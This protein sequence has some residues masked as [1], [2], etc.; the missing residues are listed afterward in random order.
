M[1]TKRKKI[2][3]IIITIIAIIGILGLFIKFNKTTKESYQ[4]NLKLAKAGIGIERGTI[5]PIY[6]PKWERV[7]T[8]V[9]T[10]NKTLSVVVKGLANESQKINANTNINYSSDVTSTLSADDITVYINGVEIT[11]KTHPKVQV[12]EG[13]VTTNTTTGK[14]E[15]THTIL[16]SDFDSG[17]L[18]KTY[19]EWSGNVTL[20]IAGR[21]KD[22]S[23]YT[24]NVLKDN[25]YGNRSMMEIDTTGTWVDINMKDETTDHY[26]AGVMFTDFID[27][28]LTYNYSTSDIN[29]DNK[30]LTMNFSVTDKYFSST[31]LRDDTTGSNLTVQ[32]KDD[33]TAPVNQNI[34]KELTYLGDINDTVNGQTVKV[35][36]RYKLVIKGLQQQTLDG[37]Y[38]NYSGPITIAFPKG[39]VK[40]KSNNPSPAK[41]ITIGVN[42]PDQTGTDKIV[43]VVDP[44]WKTQNINI[45][46]TNNKVTVDLLGTDKYYQ[47]NSLTTDKIKVIVD[48]EEATSI[49]KTLSATP[50]ALKETRNGQ[51]VQYGIQYT[52]TLEN[53]EQ[54]TKQTSPVSKQF[55]EWSG[56][57][58]IEIAKDT[59]TDQSGNTSNAQTFTLGH[60][61]FIKPKIER[62]SSTKDVTA[63]TETIVFNVFDKYLKATNFVTEDE[64]LVY[65]DNEL[66]SEITKSI[67]K[68]TEITGLVNNTNKV[69]GHQYTL[70]LGNF[71]QTRTAINFDREYSDWSGNVKIRIKEGAVEDTN[72]PTSNKNAQTDIAGEF[73]DFIKPNVTYQYSTSNIKYDNKTFTMVFD[74]TDK[75]FA[76]S[77]LTID[78]LTIKIDNKDI[79]WTK[80]SKSL[81]VTDRTNVVNGTSKVIGKRYTLELSNLEQLLVKDGDKYLDYSGV[82]TV[83]VPKNKFSD[84]SGNWNNE[85]TITSGI[86]IPGGSGNGQVVDVVD[87]LVEKISSSAN[88]INKTATVKFKV[89]DKYFAKSTITKDNIKVIINGQDTAG[90]TRTL[91]ST[92]LKE[93]RTVNGTTTTVQYGV[94]YTVTISGFASDV[95]Q[96]KVK[97]PQGY[98]T[99]TYNNGNKETDLIVYNA[100]KL[101]DSES[102]ATSGFLGSASNTN[103]TIKGI[104]RQNIDNVTFEK[105]IPN[106][107]YD[108]VAKKITDKTKAWDVSAQGDE[109]IVAWFVDNETKNGTYKIHI[110]SN[111]AQTIKEDVSNSEVFGNMNSSNLFKCIGQSENCTSAETITNLNLLNTSSV[112]NMRWMFQETGANAMTTL[113]LGDFDTSNVTHMGA[114]FAGT[115]YNKMT[116]LNLGNKFNTSKV[117]AMDYMFNNTGYM[118]MTDL[119]LGGEFNTSKVKLMQY[120]FYKTGHE[121]MVSLDLG[122][123]FNT[124]LVENMSHMFEETGYTL[125]ETLNLGGQFNTSNVTEMVAMFKNCGRKMSGLNLGKEFNTVKVT[126]MSY[127]F[128]CVGFEKL[129]SL[130]LGEKFYTSNVNNM[131]YMFAG[132]G[133]VSPLTSI[134]LGKEFDTSNVTDMGY[135]FHCAGGAALTSLDLGDKFD[136]SK[137]TNMGYMFN[138]CGIVALTSLDLGPMF[139]QI[140]SARDNMFNNT[141]KNG[142]ITI[143][144][145]EQIY[146]DKNNFKLNTNATSSAINFTRGTINPKY[147]TEWVKEASELK[148]DTSDLSKSKI[149]ITLR[150]RTNAEAGKDHTSNVSSTLTKDAV[151]VFFDNG[152]EATTITKEVATATTATNAIT[153][154]NDVIQVIT[155]SN[156]EEASRQAGKDYKEWSGNISLKID[157]K[158]LCDIY[159]NQNLKAIDTS[160]TMTD[161]VIKEDENIDANSSGTMFA[162]YIR[163][164]FT[165]KYQTEDINYG[166]KILTVDFSVT[167]KYFSSTKLRKDTKAENITVNLK[168]DKNAPVNS[169]IRKSLSYIEDIN[170]TV[171]GKTVKVGEKYRLEI[172]GLEQQTLDGKYKNYS[173]PMTL[174]FPEG[175][176]TDK[177]GNT[178]AA[179][180]ITIGVNEPDQTGSDKIVDVVDPMWRTDNIKIDHDNNK[181]TVDLIGTDKYYASNSLTTGKIK[182]IVDGEEASSITKTLSSTPEK[183]TETRNGETVQY[184]VKYTLTL[185]DW[186]QAGK[187]TDPAKSF[188]EW[189]GTT[190]IEI[191]K[192]TLTDEFGNTNIWQEFELGHVDFI[193][194]KIE[195]V[196]ST[197]NATNK[198]ETIVFNVFDKYL[199][200]TDQ[201]TADEISV[202]VDGESASQISKTLTKTSDIT[203]LVNNTSRI[204][205][206]QY[207]LVLG[208]FEQKRTS[209][210]YDREYSDWSGNV[211]IKVA[212]GAVKDTNT[213]VPNK[214]I[215]TDI[216]GEFIDF[217]KPNATYQYS[218]SDINYDGKTFTMVFDMTDKHYASGTLSLNDLAIR[219]D[220]EEPNW[221]DT[222]VHGVIKKLTVTDRTNTVNGQTKVIGKR[223]TL[224]LS[225]LEQLEKLEGKETM[226][227]SGVVTVA[228]PANKIVDTTGNKNN[229]LTITSGIETKGESGYGE[230][231]LP[232]YNTVMAIGTNPGGSNA[233][234]GFANMNVY[235]L[236]IS[237]E[238]GVISS[239]DATN[240]TGNGHNNSSTTWKDLTGSNTGTINGATWENDYLKL[241]GV[242]DWVN[243]G[244]IN[245]TNYASLDITVSM[246]SVSGEQD[247]VGNW[248]GGGVGIYLSGGYPVFEVFSKNSNKYVNIRSTS[249]I[250]VN[251]K[252][253]IKAIYDGNNLYLYINGKPVT[254]TV[255]DVVDPIWERVSSSAS[256]ANKTATVTVKGT[257]KY[258]ASSKLTADKIKVLVN[259]N[260][261]SSNVSVNVE[262]ATPVYS[263]DGTTRIGDKYT[264]T[265][266]GSG[267]PVDTDQIKVQIQP[268]TITDESGNTNKVTDLL[269]YNT[270]RKTDTETEATSGFLGS[271]NS[272]NANVKAIQRQNIDNVTFIDKI[273]STIYD[274]SAKKILDEST[275]WDVSAMQDKS[276]LAWYDT[277]ANGSIKVYIG[278]DNEIFANYN[279]SYLFKYIGF[280][281]KCTSTET[282]TNISLLNVGSVTKMNGMFWMTG[283]KSMTKLE[284]G[285]NFDTSNVESMTSMFKEAG[286]E[287]MT[288]FSLGSK[289]NT[290]KVTDMSYM[291]ANTGYELLSSLDLKDKFFTNKVTD[292]NNMF[293]GTGYTSMTNFNLGKEFNTQN[294][295][296]MKAMFSNTGFTAMT[297]LN[298]GEQFYTNKVKNMESMFEQTGYTAMTSLDLGENFDT[299]QVENMCAMFYRTGRNEMTSLNLGENFDTSNVTNMRSMFNETGA[300][301]MTSLDLGDKFY[302]NKVT[303]MYRMFVLTGASAM[304]KLDLGP[305]FTAIP[306]G[307]I[308]VN[309]N[310]VKVYDDIFYNTGKSRAITIYASEQIYLEKNNFKLNTDQTNSAIEFTR[311]TIN[312]KYRTEWVKESAKITVKEQENLNESKIEITLR[313][314]TNAE[315][316][317]NYI[318]DV[319]SSLK[320]ENIHI[321]FDGEEAT[322]ISKELSEVTT[323]T[324]EITKAQ[325]VKHVLTITNFEEALRQQGKNYKEWSGNISLKIDKKTLKDTTYGNQNLQAIDTSGTM[326]DIEI[327]ENSN[328]TQNTDGKMFTDYIKPEFTYEYAN[329]QINY[330]KKNITVVFDVTDKYFKESTVS[331]NNM[332]IKVDG[333]EPDWTKVERQFV[334][335]TIPSEQKIG[336]IIYKTNGDIYTIVNGQEQKIGE[337]YELV[338]NGLE[339]KNGEGYSGTVTLAFPEGVITD[340]SGNKNNSKTLTIGVDDP[341]NHPDHKDPTIVDVVNPLWSYGTSSI[342]RV[343]NGAEADTVDVTIIGSDKYYK[344]NTLT[345]DKIKVYVDDKLESSISKNITQITDANTLKQLA[346]KQNLADLENIKLI[347]YKVTLGNFGNISGTTKI[348]I[349]AGTIEDESGNTNIETTIPVGNPEW[350]ETGDDS[351]NPLYPAFR[352]NIVDFIK[353]TINYKYSSVTGEKNPNIDY[354]AKTLTVKFTVTDKYFRESSVMN[355]DGTLNKNNVK[356]KVAGTELTD[357]LNT[358]ITSS[359]IENGKEY[360]LVVS[361]FELAYNTSN[362]YQDYSGEVQLVF[363]AG[364]IEDTSGNRNNAKTITIDTDDGDDEDSAIIVDVVDPL[365]EKTEDNLSKMNASNAIDRNLTNET[366]TVSVVVKATDKYLSK[367][368]LDTTEN[369]AKIRV[370]VVKPSGETVYPDTITKQV[371]Q[372]SKNAT[373]VTYRITLGNFGENEGITSIII[374]EGVIIDKYGNTNRETEL[375]VGNATWTEAGD[376]K[377]EY[378]AFRDSVVDFTRPTWKY[379][380][381]SISR[382]RDEETG[383][384]TVKL[385]GNDIYYLKD[386]LTTNNIN[387]Y[388]SNSNSPDSPITTITKSLEK[389]TNEAELNGASVGYNLTLGNFG[390]YDGQ[391]KIKIA[392]DI[393]KDTSGNGNIETEILVGNKDWIEND[394]ETNTANPKYTAFRDSIVDFIK[395]IVTYK[396]AEGINPIVD[397]ENKQATIY[398]DVTDTNFLE[399]NITVDDIQILVDDMNV[400]K[401]LTKTLTSS[402]ITDNS[403]NG[404]R[405]R[406]TLSNFELDANLENEIFRRHSGK[407]EL[408]VA[409]SKVKD[410]SGNTNIETRIIVDNDNGDDA[411]NYIKVDFIKPKL[412][413][414]DKFISWAQRYATVTIAGTDRFYDFD[415]KLTANDISIYELN[416][417]GQYVQRTDLPI[418]VTP[419]RTQYGYNFVVR[420]D[421]FEE[422]FK[423]LK[424]S[425]PANKIGDTE[426]HFNEATDIFVDLD[427]K[428]PVWKY[429][430]SDT[431]KFESENS[432]S[433]T[434]KGQDTFLNLERSGLTNGNVKIYKDGKDITNTDNITVT[435]LGAD[436]TEIS[437]TFKIDVKGLT[438]IG[439]YSLVLQKETLIDDFENKS[440]T[441]TISFSKSAISS[442]TDNYT[443]VTYHVTPDF[444]QMHQAYIHELMSVN[445]TGTNYQNTTYRASSIGEIYSNGLNTPFAEPFKYENGVQKAYSFNGWAVASEKGFS[446]EN[447]K[448][449][450][451]YEEIP[452]TVTHLNAVWQEATVVFVSKNGKNS[453]DGKSPTTP[454]KDL[455]TAYSKLNSSGNASNNIIVVMDAIEWNSSDTLKGNATIT[456][457]YAGVDYMATGAELKISS[458]INIAG[459]ITFDNI[460]L[461]SNSSTVNNGK[462]SLAKG[463]YSNVLITNYGDVILGRGIVTPLDKY[464]FGAVV[465]GNYKTEETAGTIGIHKVIIESGKYNDI[466]AGSS[467]ETNTQKNKYITHEITI[468]TMKESAVN[469]NDKVTITGY[470][471][472]GEAEDKCYPFNSEGLQSA[473]S[474]YGL[475]YSKTNIY[476]ATFTGENKY[477]EDAENASIYLRTINGFTDGKTEFNIYCGD[478]N[479]NVYAGSREA[480]T[481]A[482]DSTGQADVNMLNFYGG[483]INGDI[484]GHGNT[485]STGNSILT[486]EGCF[487]ITGNIFGGSKTTKEGTAK[488]TGNT[489]IRINSSIII[490]GNIYGGSSGVITKSI[491]NENTG[492]I[493]GDTNITLNAGTVKGDIF[494]GGYDCGATGSSNITIKNG[495]VI[496]NTYGGAYQNQVKTTANINILGGTVNNVY[497]GNVLTIQTQQN[498]DTT[499]QNANIV[500]GKTDEKTTPKVNGKIFGSG[501][502]DRVGKAKIQLIKCATTPTVYG[503]SDG[504]GITNETEIYLKGMT[505][506]TIYGGSD[507]DGIVT[508]S[509]I[510]LQTGTTTD[511]Y[512]GGYGGT[513]TTSNVTFE[514]SST[515]ESI[516]GGSNTNGTVGTSNIQLKSGNLTNV[517]G[518]GNSAIVGSTNVTLDGI[519]IDAIYGAAKNAGATTNTN[520][521]LKSGKV[522]DAFGGGYN[523]GATNAKVTQKGAIVTNIFGGT[524]GLIESAGTTTN[525]NITVEN[526]QANNVYGGNKNN[527][528]TKNAKINISGTSKILG[529]LYGGGYNT[530]IGTASITGTTIINISGGIISNDVNG[531]S[532]GRTVHGKVNINIGKDTV[533]DNTLQEGNIEIKGNIYGAGND[534]VEGDTYIVLDNSEQSPIT[535]NNSIFGSGDGVDYSDNSTVK[536]KDF[537]TAESAYNMISIQ[538][539]GKVFVQNSYLELMG[540]QDANNYYQRTSY[541]LNRVSKGLTLLD[542]STLY[543]RRGFNMVG[544]FE[545]LKTSDNGTT[546]KETVNI[547][548]GT[549]TQNVNNRLYTFEGVNLIFAKQEGELSDRANED[550][551]GDVNG[552]AFFGMYRIGRT[553]GSKEYDIYDPDYSGT[554]TTKMFANG[555]Y[556][557]GRHKTSHDITVDGFYTNVVGESKTATPQVIEITDY[558]RYYDW[559]VG[560]D[561]VNYNTSVIA[562][563]YSTYAM[564]ELSLDFKKF[565]NNVT[566]SGTSFAVDRVSTNALNTD[567]N[568]TDKLTLPT[569]SENANNTFAL[570]MNTSDEGWHKGGTTNIYT[571]NNGSFDGD[572]IFRTDNSGTPSTLVFRIFNSVNVTETKDL[573]YI[574]VVLTAKARTGEDAS[575]GNTFKV[576]IAINIQSL[577]EQDKECYMPSF[578][579][580]IETE[581]NYTTDA[582]VNISY[583]LYK[584]AVKAQTD[585]YKTGDYRV[586]S[587]SSPLPKDT[588]I[589]LKDKGNSPNKV[590][591]YQTTSDS[592]YDAT[593]NSTGSTRYIYKLSK[594]IEMGGSDKSAKYEDDNSKYYHNGYALEK[595]D[596]TID[597]IDSN[598]D[599]NRLAQETYL[600]LKASSG[601]T[602]YNNDDKIVKYNLYNDKA[603]FEE[604]VVTDDG[605][606]SYTVFENLTIPFSFDGIIQEKQTANGDN[607][608]DTKY[609]DK[610]AGLAV[611]ITSESGERVKAPEIQNLKIYDKTDSKYY[612]VGADGVIRIPLS[613]GLAQVHNKYD[614]ILTQSSVPSGTYYAKIYF[615]SSDDG[616]HYTG[617]IS[618][619]EQIRIIFI[620]KLLGLAGLEAV[621]NSRIINK[622]TRLN[623]VN[624]DGLDFTVTLSSPTEDT[625]VRVELYKRS[626]TYTIAEDGTA[627]YNDIDYTKVDLKDYLENMDGSEWKT[628]EKCVDQGLITE[629]GSKEYMVIER[630]ERP[631]D[632]DYV[633][634]VKFNKKIKE[635]ISTGEYRL[636]FKA[637]S[638]NTLVQAISKSFIVTP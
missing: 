521:V 559:I 228:I 487:G 542:N 330:D 63:K 497:G 81:S 484:F 104:Q 115:G 583:M 129:Q 436:E 211:E 478:V 39:V 258:F 149:T 16:L 524:N 99:D 499:S 145:S 344:T 222:G 180:S 359:D 173:G 413:Y 425:I 488:V 577:Y 158:T 210:N 305:A 78:D 197:K 254:G 466:I 244:Q 107:I 544:G 481:K 220:G 187:Q 209:I 360:T 462:N 470:L 386:T 356:I 486:F 83:V 588:K 19:K 355:A 34:T 124:I 111:T 252:T 300:G 526:A 2:V 561:I 585:I 56:T 269:V 279:S 378:T 112:T 109:S 392:E 215:A 207:T 203:A 550:I 338:L 156:L 339:T 36:E 25:D 276:I 313:G 358:T 366:G 241:D 633:E 242:N 396:Y 595:Y 218:T 172:V 379:S 199:D 437:K 402:D 496:G 558:G 586:L 607:I 65:V 163:P 58:K 77:T 435:D 204:V 171:D 273:P 263:A 189:S 245:F 614:L 26:Q 460:K 341:S 609:Y 445:K 505:T 581:L 545:S 59:I 121:V 457:L 578:T 520:V 372:M 94:E 530:D 381:S 166:D 503:G 135:M 113:N 540:A 393:I 495:Q 533:T 117:T 541:T 284:L 371:Y 434:V 9:D 67:T 122:G 438:E 262:N 161:I 421:E 206:Q 388:V 257:D 638:N 28:E 529:E 216:A 555:T 554:A 306:S 622:N 420:L 247:L 367:G 491:V 140:S 24:S 208:N 409:P 243:L 274:K 153:G 431:T 5:N 407:I 265:F 465:G 150:G 412:Y 451:L 615:F 54:T 152:K 404:V 563:T 539:T 354:E 321:L 191:S 574:N 264:I 376:T 137:V 85:K 441:T 193:Q 564:S 535:F 410:T 32:L 154:A 237:N 311:G 620:N 398:F 42:E 71:E 552:M 567:V 125:M 181:V 91:T 394:V 560:V 630:K 593:D 362:E 301:K 589:T 43:D 406:L 52:L 467:L 623:L 502:F 357:K 570:T 217:I 68:R 455:Q 292:M 120:M 566:Y 401:T 88:A 219:V 296:N 278:S 74:V 253:N 543:T 232:A 442:N 519:T 573:G 507:T 538:R 227:Y 226:D 127:M 142:A 287:K 415:T 536:V 461:Y 261:I 266:N 48:G 601:I 443:I 179:K 114:M 229:A 523:I 621:D 571:N 41:A 160:G 106:S 202:Y 169:N 335:K 246:N 50:T 309:E 297:T 164:E 602:K 110:A 205:G 449:Y 427:N 29:Y 248:E 473:N 576:V 14:T 290:S 194:P 116:T 580:R 628:P 15:V 185:S 385:L 403:K 346:T 190:K 192:N 17:R 66:A 183:L 518:G 419:V 331:L 498:A 634:R 506:N 433:F 537:G 494:G 57:T 387:V 128:Y 439:N 82:I 177:S 139:I 315:A 383:T 271:A 147:R 395:P 90:I 557:E 251:E 308:V 275:T 256:A 98:V 454:V 548:N 270:L 432:I 176:I 479:G 636:V 600:E 468:G 272:T 148:I 182:V 463:N 159:G 157:K 377:G 299:S 397:Q 102:E 352:D 35:G 294:V 281:D 517:Y 416:R 231:G 483:H 474:G 62:V 72:T 534:K 627:S 635:G 196:S 155:L 624:G 456:S 136:T 162:D 144:A 195:R 13:K 340:K 123:Q 408:I 428:K 459:D 249:Q 126:N 610:I 89:T 282:I 342:N 475:Y 489:N 76:S 64:I 327:K 328:T 572:S 625:N 27:P 277:N 130:D 44:M 198:T 188:F 238:T 7:S 286:R 280:S 329:T 250:K 93:Q 332:T 133:Q 141:G 260:E 61:D 527:G 285:D 363:A 95:N 380:T 174:A 79:D 60:V 33:P 323:A 213:P 4:A 373:S 617:T 317:K 255:V 170:D 288:T 353:P 18:G 444:E 234:S 509:K 453:N 324:N 20:K 411:N 512:G 568:L 178:S 175:T 316:G 334:K 53:W 289:F 108:H 312:P 531:G 348:V 236:E 30:T 349:E 86:N 105:M 168:D 69:I 345:P 55:F 224:K 632:A 514:G 132:V 267:L 471:A 350:T 422:E 320:A 612:E 508:T 525:S 293:N 200:T 337:R 631:N 97:I 291:F 418:T 351:T 45:D 608:Q 240:N 452:N 485:T 12:S 382:N 399:S 391:V 6:K 230:I 430:S 513:T 368:T 611:E 322:S 3:K 493:V 511:V 569:Y 528:I 302:T 283:W 151:H 370:K 318:S 37:N 212:A 310:T 51:S 223:Y 92:E 426:G 11:D 458:N 233:T 469:R 599:T 134:N 389:I 423:Q 450:G 480:K 40:D 590:Y 201:V 165:Y 235:S 369:V 38:K 596:V 390:T 75:H 562:S 304:T 405:Y 440:N 303:N 138:E 504:S 516:F 384:V 400:T 214:N 103:A 592:D 522:K 100:L 556:I 575:I 10:T 186:E 295:E 325:D 515:V 326:K 21:G 579:D 374:P 167:D 298:L 591:Y 101:T 490:D 597:Y 532:K 146:L 553:S 361:N 629:T 49:K 582:S 343:R 365:V 482:S 549:V 118:K 587:T 22:E 46:H 551:W 472:M 336:N 606:T 605:N 547:E 604:N 414:V 8:T 225:H 131:S 73:I 119:I 319:T 47:S 500:I 143:Y 476:S 510:Y 424:I 448:V 447:S 1:L 375:L 239:Y 80:V 477:S 446:D 364:K 603:N 594:F 221:D 619:V 417:N 429:M 584:S 96:V 347:G 626:P 598:L 616:L 613:D 307:T 70:V 314:R 268:G 546:T 184:G 87:P 501:K 464:T 492:A 31:D 23:T 565:V 637:Y 333:V 259:G 84:T 618:Q